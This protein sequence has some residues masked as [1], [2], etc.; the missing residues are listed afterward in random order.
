MGKITRY[1]AVIGAILNSLLVANFISQIP[2]LLAVVLFVISAL[3]IYVAGK[4]I[5]DYD[6]KNK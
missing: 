3:V 4:Q 6:I 2:V 1:I 5:Y